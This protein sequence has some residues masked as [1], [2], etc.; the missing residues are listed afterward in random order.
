MSD[1]GDEFQA[2][3]PSLRRA[4]D[5]AFLK[6]LKQSEAEFKPARKKRRIAEQDRGSD[7]GGFVKE[8][9]DGGMYC[10]NRPPHPG[11]GSY[12][13]CSEHGSEGPSDDEEQGVPLS[14]VPTGLQ[15]R[16]AVT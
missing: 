3:K 2:L 1:S 9:G 7:T 16:C 5:T 13:L 6:L 11:S 8:G 4:I 15:V 12:R 10:H 14:L